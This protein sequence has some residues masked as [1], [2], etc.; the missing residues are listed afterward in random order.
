[1]CLLVVII[2]LQF[3]VAIAAFVMRGDLEESLSESIRKD[4]VK[5]YHDQ[6]EYW[7]DMQKEVKYK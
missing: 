7:D 6:T 4:I 3:A 1:M 5:M 2:L